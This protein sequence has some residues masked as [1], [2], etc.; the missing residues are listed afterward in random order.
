ML[1]KSGAVLVALALAAT[2]AALGV[3]QLNRAEEKAG[4]MAARA[5]REK[6][7]RIGAERP[8]ASLGAD[9]SLDQQRVELIG[10][11]LFERTIFLDNR[12]WQGRLGVH[13]LT[14]LQLRDGSVVWVNRGWIEK[15]P[16]VITPPDPP[17]VRDPEGSSA[18]AALEGVAM[19]SVMRRMELSTDPERLRQGSIWQN[20]D[21]EIARQR[22]PLPTWPVI[23]WQTSDNQDEL[24]RALP[25]V[26]SDVPKHQGYALQ[27]FLMSAVALFFA[28]RLRK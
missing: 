5:E 22:V 11:W 6:P 7:I 16:G 10:R 9:F 15:P 3:W 12:S 13:V 4:L 8:L 26:A 17:K 28:W 2:A 1:N 27:W 25:E 23:V 18:A 14:P 24:R 20:F 19:D 21:W